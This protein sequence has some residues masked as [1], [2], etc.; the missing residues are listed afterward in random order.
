MFKIHKRR[1]QEIFEEQVTT[2]FVLDLLDRCVL[3]EGVQTIWTTDGQ[4]EENS[5]RQSPA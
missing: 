4:I 1:N 5:C 3:Y 2:N